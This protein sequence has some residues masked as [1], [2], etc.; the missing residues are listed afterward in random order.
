[1]IRHWGLHQYGEWIILTAIPTYLMLSPDFGLAGAVVNQMAISTTEG[2]RNDAICMYRTSW[3]FLTIMA[4]CFVLIG[5]A[6]SNWVNWQPLGVTLLSK[7]AAAIISLSLIQIFIGQ[8]ILLLSG[9]YRCARRNPRCGALGSLGYS[10]V[11]LVGCI[12]LALSGDPVTFISA[13]VAARLVFLCVLLFDARRMMPDFTLGIRGVSLNAIR[14][15]IIPGLGHAT[16]PLIN[17]LQNEGTVL[18]L[19]VILGPVSVA[20]FQ[21]TRTAVNGARSLTGLAA[22]AVMLEIPALVGEGRLN[23]VRRLLVVNTQVALAAIGGWLLLLAVFGGPIFHLWLH[24]GA[25]YSRPLVLLMMASMF[26]MA[27]AD[28]FRALLLATNQ[29]HKAVPLLLPAALISLAVTAAGGF[30]FGLN[31]AAF[32]MFA[33]ESMSLL[34]VCTVAS[35]RTQIQVKATLAEVFSKHSVARTYNSALSTLRLAKCEWS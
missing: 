10:F 34:V 7:H 5:I 20:I 15:Y 31:G 4:A 1:M 24:N 28:S 25:V 35:R 9:I 33:F 16:M 23:T 12:T 13:N 17:A 27:F 18:A 8:Q 21:T 26:P 29:I 14:P 32:G 22:S 30:L 6:V 3:I 11:L 19:G 2:K